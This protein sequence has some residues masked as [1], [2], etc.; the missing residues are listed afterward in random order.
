MTKK[1]SIYICDD[2]RLFLE[3]IEVFISLQEKY[4]CVGHAETVEHAFQDVVRLKPDLI[5]IDYHLQDL[6]AW[7]FWKRLKKQLSR[8]SVLSLPCAVT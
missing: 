8:R 3:S 4:H 7:N 1:Y 5:L 6:M 2:H